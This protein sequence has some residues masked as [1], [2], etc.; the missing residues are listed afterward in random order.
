MEKEKKAKN[1]LRGLVC[2]SPSKICKNFKIKKWRN[3]EELSIET[4]TLTYTSSAPTH[5]TKTIFTDGLICPRRRKCI[6]EISTKTLF[7]SIATLYLFYV[8]Y[9][10][11]TAA[12]SKNKKKRSSLP[13][14]EWLTSIKDLVCHQ[15]PEIPKKRKTDRTKIYAYCFVQVEFEMYIWLNSSH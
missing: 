6:K 5:K 11:S 13:R 3:F 1:N 2:S 15:K 4:P 10:S 7:T 9:I 12:K 8:R 14:M